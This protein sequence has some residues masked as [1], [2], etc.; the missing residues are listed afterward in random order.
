MARVYRFLPVVAAGVLLAACGDDA[1]NME[2]VGQGG[3]QPLNFDHGVYYFPCTGAD[4]A[5]ALS[6]FKSDN[7]TLSVTGMTG[8][9]TFTYGKDRGYFVNTQK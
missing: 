5:N 7:P 2:N 6:K 4:F 9:G 3:C 1:A 8:N